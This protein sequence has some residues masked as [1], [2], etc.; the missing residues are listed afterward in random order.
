MEQ[1]FMVRLADMLCSLEKARQ[2]MSAWK[3]HNLEKIK[4][5]KRT[6]Y[7]RHWKF[8]AAGKKVWAERHQSP[9]R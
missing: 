1:T 5:Q 2:H 3:A 9:C 4:A 6:W 8:I 7:A